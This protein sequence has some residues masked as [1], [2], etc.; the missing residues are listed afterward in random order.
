MLFIW[1]F[2]KTC[3]TCKIYLVHLR[4]RLIFYFIW[5]SQEIWLVF[6]Q[7]D[8]GINIQN[9]TRTLFIILTENEIIFYLKHT[10]QSIKL[11][12]TVHHTLKID[13]LLFVRINF[14]FRSCLDLV[15]WGKYWSVVM[16]ASVFGVSD[17]FT[18]SK[19]KIKAEWGY[20]D[21]K[22]F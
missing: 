3:N 15:R 5:N 11:S 19:K 12:G 4:L 2:E 8:L 6:K 22:W 9:S 18:S 21:W 1:Y 20:M 10:L 14:M 17:I 16:E 13:F 7:I